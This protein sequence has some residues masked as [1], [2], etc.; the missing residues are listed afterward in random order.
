MSE[1]DKLSIRVL[2]HATRFIRN[3]GDGKEAFVELECSDSS[4]DEIELAF[5][6]ERDRYYVRIRRADLH[7]L[8]AEVE[9]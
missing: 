3:D 6:L 2:A 7:R 1:S 4:E 9:Q 5:T 8:L